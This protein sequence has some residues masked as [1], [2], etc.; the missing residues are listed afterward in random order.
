[1]FDLGLLFVR[2]V[3]VRQPRRF[4]QLLEMFFELF[5]GCPLAE[6]GGSLSRQNSI[7]KAFVPV[8]ARRFGYTSFAL[9]PAT[10]DKSVKWVAL[11][12]DSVCTAC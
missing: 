5:A 11:S 1:M 6:G 2:H 3:R 7:F 4:P 10:R 9:Y 12:E 8:I